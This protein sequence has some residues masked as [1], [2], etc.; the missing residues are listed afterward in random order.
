M[1][2]VLVFKYSFLTEIYNGSMDVAYTLSNINRTITCSNLK[3][4]S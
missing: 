1:D 3:T 4:K 2:I